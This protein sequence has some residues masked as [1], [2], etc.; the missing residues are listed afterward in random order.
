M[1]TKIIQTTIC[2]KKKIMQTTFSTHNCNHC[3]CPKQ[4]TATRWPKLILHFPRKQH[5][6]PP[7]TKLYNCLSLPLQPAGLEKYL[8]EGN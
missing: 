6:S 4:D 1:D 3:K 7:N 8:P 5:I 2:T